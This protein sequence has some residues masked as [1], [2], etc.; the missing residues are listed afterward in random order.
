MKLLYKRFI[1]I[2]LD[3]LFYKFLCVF[4]IINLCNR[5]KCLLTKIK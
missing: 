4:S 2:E 5:K 3:L 1:V